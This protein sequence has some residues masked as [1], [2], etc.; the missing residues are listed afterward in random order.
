MGKGGVAYNLCE[1][2]CVGEGFV[3]CEHGFAVDCWVEDWLGEGGGGEGLDFC[4]C[5]KD[6]LV[7]L[8]P[9]ARSDIRAGAA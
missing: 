7:I 5:A 1:L 8:C 3:V 4:D 9:H 6:G 2:A